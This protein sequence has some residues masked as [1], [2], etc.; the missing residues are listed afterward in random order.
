MDEIRQLQIEDQS[1]GMLLLALTDGSTRPK[2][3]VISHNSESFKT[4]WRQWERL[5]V[6][7]S[8]LYREF[9]DTEANKVILQ[10]IVPKQ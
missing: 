5:K 9:H 3:D 10:L 4:L 2:W 8:L 7:N 1:I 6:I